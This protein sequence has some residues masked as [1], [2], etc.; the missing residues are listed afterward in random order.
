[1]AR[2]QVMVRDPVAETVWEVVPKSYNFTEKLN[3]EPIGTF[4]LSFDEIAQ[5]AER[6]G[7]TVLSIF[8][9]ALREI[10]VERNGVKIF[11]GVVT[12]L[13]V[14]PVGEGE[15]SLTIKAMGYFG[16]FKKR[17]VGVGSEVVYSATDAGE[18]AWDLIDDS[19]GSD[20]PYSDWGITEGTIQASKNRD[21]TYLFDNI[22]DSIVRLSNN[23][24]A[25]GFD[26]E[27]DNNKAFNVYYPTKGVDR[28]AL[29]FDERT[30]AGWKYKKRLILDMANKVYSLGEGFNEDVLYETRTASTA[31]RTP[32]GTLEEKI[33]A[34]DVTETAT[35]QDKGDAR[36]AEAASPPIILDSLSHYDD[37]IQ[38]SDYDLGDTVRANFPDLEITDD[39]YR[40]IERRFTMDDKNVA[41]ITNKVI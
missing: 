24:L 32:F 6:N 7:T 30:S 21:R 2:Y 29:T 34:Y 31:L 11:Y 5:M 23:N 13:E 22:Y 14:G 12:D 25:E 16:L 33:Q 10:Y 3:Q 1:M 28:P 9:S 35:L 18:I 40:I 19:Q 15:K 36:L 41:L 39:S 38:Y 20:T 17:I 8:T 37:S 27:I 26:F 4:Y